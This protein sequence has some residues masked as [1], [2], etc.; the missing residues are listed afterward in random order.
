MSKFEAAMRPLHERWLKR[1]AE[2]R[3]GRLVSKYRVD[4]ERVAAPHLPLAPEDYD[5]DRVPSIL[6]IGQSPYG[7]MTLDCDPPAER[8]TVEEC[9][10]V[11]R[12]VLGQ[13][14]TGNLACSPFWC[15]AKMLSA[16]VAERTGVVAKPLTNVVW[17]NVAKISDGHSKV[18]PKNKLWEAQHK[19]AV[20]TIAKEVEIYQ[21]TLIVAVVGNLYEVAVRPALA[22][23]APGIEDR[24]AWRWNDTDRKPWTTRDSNPAV[25]WCGHPARKSGKVLAS[26]VAEAASLIPQIGL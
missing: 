4:P 13:T 12:K 7:P 15:F 5:P 10:S 2:L 1:F 9:H 22:S 14:V 3:S 16:A 23:C 17:T 18:P 21:P 25:F 24:R 8:Y 6:L 11:T 20:E 26:W 19:L